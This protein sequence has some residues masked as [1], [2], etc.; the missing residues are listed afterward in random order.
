MPNHFHLLLK[1]N[2]KG[3]FQKENQLVPVQSLTR[4][5]ALL[6][7]SYT[8]AIHKQES[9]QGSLFQQKTK[10]KIL[11]PDTLPGKNLVST[12]LHYI[13][14]NPLKAGLVNRLEDWEFS[15]YRDYAGI[16]NGTLCNIQMGIDL[17]DMQMDTFVNDSYGVMRDEIIEKVLF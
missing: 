1:P 15:S 9:I 3:C 11:L 5:I 17:A 8:R 13:H 14:Q 6:Q 7:S 2:E 4:K 10:A 16:R 12:C